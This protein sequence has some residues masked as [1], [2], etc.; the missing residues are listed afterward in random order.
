[1]YVSHQWDIMRQVTRCARLVGALYILLIGQGLC[2]L[3]APAVLHAQAVFTADQLDDL[4]APIA[5]Y[6]D[7]LLAQVLVAASYPDEIDLAAR[8]VRGRGVAVVDGEG[9]DV[10]VR[11]VAHY[12]SVLDRMADQVDWTTTLGQAYVEDPVAVMAAVQR[13]RARAYAEGNLVTTRYEEVIVSDGYYEIE[14][15]EP[16]FIYVPTYDP[17]VIFFRRVYVN[18]GFGAYLSFGAPLPIGAWLDFDINWGGHA[19]VYNGWSGGGAGWR[20]RSR[21]Y[22][23]LT[24]AYVSN[25][26]RTVPI[27]RAVVDRPVNYRAL[28]RFHAVH[29]DP[30]FEMHAAAARTPAARTPAARTPAARVA[31][32]RAA[33]PRAAASR[34]PAPRTAPLRTAAPRTAPT[35]HRAPEPARAPV[36]APEV[37]QAPRNQTRRAAVTPSRPSRPTRAATRPTTAPTRPTAAP[38]RPTAAPTR[39]TAAPARPSAAPARTSAAR[40]GRPAHP[41]PQKHPPGR[42]PPSDSIANGLHRT[43]RGGETVRAA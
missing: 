36:R 2:G 23:K 12:P 21:P 28:D 42:K 33:A 9:W 20:A 15:L 7:P 43:T 27:N 17:A 8:V 25:A 32:P 5:L 16:Q 24:P 6:P 34:T 38:T 39:P 41:Q 13:M 18:G 35:E 26:Y 19:V 1:M 11:A 31:A 30:R 10:S 37:M 29:A 3:A 4:V 22:V 40:S 14:P